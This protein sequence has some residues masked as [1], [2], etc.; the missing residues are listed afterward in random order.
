MANLI[1]KAELVDICG[2]ND[3]VEDR[4]VSRNIKEAQLR[5]ERVLGRTLYG[6]LKTA[7]DADP[8]L[9][10]ASNE[11]FRNLLAEGKG[12]AEEYLAWTAY[13]LSFPGLHSEADRGGFFTK[14]GE[15]YRPVT[16]KELS[17]HI[18]DA[19]DRADDRLDRMIAY[20]T[21]NSATYPEYGTTTGSEKRITESMGGGFIL[22]PSDR[23]TSYRG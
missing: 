3:L 4:K 12:F 22:T 11:R 10:G 13:L 15:D 6:L 23:Q 18:A 8:T 20:L 16:E 19:R 7:F 5:L 17:V 1:T 21:D 2:L 9:A 14:S